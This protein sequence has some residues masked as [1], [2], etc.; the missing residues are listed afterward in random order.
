MQT[1]E[2]GNMRD[3]GDFR[4]NWGKQGRPVGRLDE[5]DFRVDGGGH[6]RQE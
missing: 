2:L 4:A 1:R 6:S 3:Y 5:T